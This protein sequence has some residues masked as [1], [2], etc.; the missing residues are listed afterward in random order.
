MGKQFSL[1]VGSAFY[2]AGIFILTKLFSLLKIKVDAGI[3]FHCL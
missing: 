1:T 3:V 2:T